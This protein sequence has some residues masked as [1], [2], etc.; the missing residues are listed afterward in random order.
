MYL[1]GPWR[2]LIDRDWVYIPTPIAVGLTRWHFARR[3]YGP[4]YCA[5]GARFNW[6]SA[7]SWYC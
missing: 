2:T 3:M 7:G 5:G 4:H 6:T 1:L